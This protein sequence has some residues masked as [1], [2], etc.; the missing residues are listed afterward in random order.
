MLIPLFLFERKLLHL[1]MFYASEYLEQQ[2]RQEYYDR[3]L[4][5]SRDDD[6][7][8]WCEFFLV[9]VA[10]QAGANEEKARQIL[11]LYESKKDFVVSLTHSQYSIAALD[12][13]F[14]FPVFNASDFNLRA[15]IPEQTARRFLR[16]LC[17]NGL[18]RTLQ[19]ASGRRPGGFCIS[20]TSEHC[21]G[22]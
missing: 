20:R 16:L 18:L 11:E 22:T 4:A 10:E 5:V 9:A 2:R 17:D 12:F 13:L 8:G 21:R 19:E 15:G 14:N 3:L 6:W 1:P 7:T